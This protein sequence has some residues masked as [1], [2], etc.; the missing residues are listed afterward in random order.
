MAWDQSLAAHHAR[1]RAH[2]RE[3]SG[4]YNARANQTCEQRYHA[5]VTDAMRGR[6]RVLELGSGSNALLDIVGTPGSVACDLSVDMLRQRRLIAKTT[7]VVGAGEGLPFRDASFD[8]MYCI[9]VLEHVADLAAV[10]AEAGRVL[11]PG[12]VFFAVTPNGGWE[13]WLDLAERMRMKIPEGPHQF[14]TRRALGDTLR[15]HFEIV[16]HRTFLLVPGGPPAFSAAADRLTP[17]GLGWGF[18]QHVRARRV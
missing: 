1:V 4:V 13:R 9:N 16:E 8:G 15:R 11:A 10:V 7:A 17:H 5:L 14:L 12:G 2:Y 6:K 3:L 18:F